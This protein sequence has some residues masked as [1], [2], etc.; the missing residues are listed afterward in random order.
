MTDPIQ[1]PLV[2]VDANPFVYLVEGSERDAEPI[3]AL[4]DNLRVRPGCAV[5]SELTLAEV[6][7]GAHPPPHRRAYLELII[8]SRIFDLQPVSRDIL[9]ETADYRRI[10]RRQGGTETMVKLPDAIHVV[11]AIRTRCSW[12]LSND[13][14]LRLPDGMH[15]VRPDSDGVAQLIQELS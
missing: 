10:S 6:L 13:T 9:I 4:F 11:T 5:T 3:K 15:L 1:K 14:G 2:Y 12:L 8:W 7:A